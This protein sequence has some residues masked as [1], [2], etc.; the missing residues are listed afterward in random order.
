VCG[1]APCTTPQS[2]E[3]SATTSRLLMPILGKF[4]GR[5][6]RE[7]PC[8]MGDPSVDRMSSGHDPPSDVTFAGGSG[9]GCVP[10]APQRSLR[11]VL[12]SG[13]TRGDVQPLLAVAAE[14]LQRGHRPVV[15]LSKVHLQW[16]RAS[17]CW[18]VPDAVAPPLPHLTATGTRKTHTGGECTAS[19]RAAQGSGQWRAA[20]AASQ[21]GS[22]DDP[23][24][25]SARAA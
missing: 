7:P 24:R 4:S 21:L 19:G 5:S 18:T 17:G 23:H 3:S 25:R 22:G 8:S 6:R 20:G 11:V 9:A 12:C 1:G 13:G 16:V 15:C 10:G 14:L 2:S